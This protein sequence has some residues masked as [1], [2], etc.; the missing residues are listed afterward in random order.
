MFT[1]LVPGM[2]WDK[3]L[4]GLPGLFLCLRKLQ[5]YFD[6]GACL[7]TET[8]EASDSLLRYCTMCVTPALL[9]K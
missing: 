8:R 6:F 7:Q 3:P 9:L 1:A 2:Q 5:P 4:L